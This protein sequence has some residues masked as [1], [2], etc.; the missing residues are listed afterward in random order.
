LRK[1]RLFFVKSGPFRLKAKRS[2]KAGIY[3]K[4]TA[5]EAKKRM[6][7][8]NEY[9]LL[10]V[11]APWEYEQE[12]ISGAVLMPDYEFPKRAP[13]ELKDTACPIFIYCKSG[14]R[15]LVC[16]KWLAKK[17]YARVYDF[18]SID[19]WPYGTDTS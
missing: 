2:R 4:I 3:K 5:Q 11:R 19:D 8:L 14:R 1:N 12:R 17:G 6:D 7:E 9:I 10:D 13:D 15:S 16:A 18:G